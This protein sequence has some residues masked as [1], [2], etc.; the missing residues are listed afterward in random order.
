MDFKKIQADEPPCPFMD[1]IGCKLIMEKVF[2]LTGHQPA[3]ACVA[4]V[5]LEDCKAYRRSQREHATQG[6]GS[7]D[8]PEKGGLW[9]TVRAMNQD[10]S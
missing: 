8:K 7:E 3:C 2:E 6:L 1:E 9:A 5:L 4:H 10:L